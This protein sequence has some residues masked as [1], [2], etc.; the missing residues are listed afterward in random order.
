M[1]QIKIALSSIITGT[2]SMSSGQLQ[3]DLSQDENLNKALDNT[4]TN[5]SILIFRVN[6]N[7]ANCGLEQRRTHIISS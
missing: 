4:S 5:P 6:C 2:N 7:I 3:G 1:L